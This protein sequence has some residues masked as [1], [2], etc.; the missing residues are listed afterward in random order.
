MTIKKPSSEE[1]FFRGEPMERFDL[2]DKE[3][4]FLERTAQRGEAL[5]DHEFFLVVHVWVED[6]KGRFLIQKRAKRTDATYG[7]WATTTGIPHAGE[8]PR[9]A[10]LREMDEELGVE[11]DFDEL[12][13]LGRILTQGKDRLNTITF[14]YR[15]QKNIEPARLTPA[16]AEVKDVDLATLDEILALVHE[17][18]FWDYADILLEKDYFRLLKG[19]D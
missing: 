1:G 2:Y 16:P 14:V 9:Q 4:R 19:R 7:L 12:E 8:T 18:K 11:L 15:V 10:A 5:A 6:D 17:G 13:E 3:G